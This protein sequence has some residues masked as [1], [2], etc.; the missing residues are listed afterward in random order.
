MKTLVSIKKD[1]EFNSG[2]ASL[3]EVLKNIAVSQYRS[4]E[5][6]LKSYPEFT[7][8]I[9]GFF[10]FFDPNKV[11]HPFLIP[12]NKTQLVLAITSDSG[13]LGGLNMRVVSTA[14]AELNNMSGNLVVVG[15]RGKIYA[16]ESGVPFVAFS[17]ITDEDRQAQS[18]QLRDYLI[19]TFWEKKMGYLK[20]IYPHPVS[21]TIQRVE[22]V[23]IL[24]FAVPPKEKTD[25]PEEDIIME[26]SLADILAYLVYLLMGH[27]I[28]EI[29]GLSRLAEFA[30][31]F[32]HL[33][34]SSQRLKEMDQKLRLQYFKVRHELIDR[35]MRELFSARLLYAG[36]E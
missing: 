28:Y 27:R 5:K 15:E 2:L 10:G 18:L 16:R 14:L 7:E 21:F 36:Q 12:T 33:E 24:P 29:L 30:A 25:V 19:N 26:S 1:M 4:L 8:Y 6:K 17:G 35:N 11:V 13:L 20:V 3:I 22:I 9:Q 31:R 23:S 32:I 34:E